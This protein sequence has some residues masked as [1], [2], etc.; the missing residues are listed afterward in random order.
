[1]TTVDI[2]ILDARVADALPAYATPGRAGTM[3]PMMPSIESAKAAME[4][5]MSI[6]KCLAL[7]RRNY[8]VSRADSSGPAGARGRRRGYLLQR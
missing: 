8:P 6:E 2:R 1:M 7:R 4:R 3:Q 5:V